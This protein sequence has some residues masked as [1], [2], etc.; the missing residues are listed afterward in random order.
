M[1]IKIILIGLISGTLIGTVGVGGILLTPLLMFFVGTELHIAQASSSFS[2]L[3]TGVVGVVIYARQKSIDWNQVLWISVGII[4][5][6]LLGA[7]VN[8]ILSGT[9]LTVIL[10]ILIT[11]SGYNALTKEKTNAQPRQTLNKI[12]RIL[13]GLGVG[14][15]SSLT[16]TGGP[17]L[18][19]PIL[20][21]LQF[22]PLVAVGISQA[23][24]LPIAIFA[25]I[26]FILY[27]E[28]D[29][30]LGLTLGIVQSLSVI[31]GAKIAHSLPHEKLRMV[32]AITLVGVGFL[33]IGRVLF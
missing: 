12:T 22:M 10:A 21:L 33:M 20:L 27:G 28:I 25:T 13:I 19:V 6:T 11:F 7:K 5:A 29:F 15:G 23:I 24:Q 30:S 17:V 8:T 26:G 4:P 9:V 3:F 31:F 18:L 2:F 1:L 14:F 16:G 32:V